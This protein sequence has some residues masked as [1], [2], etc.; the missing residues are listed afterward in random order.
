M[1]DRKQKATLT[2][3]ALLEKLRDAD[4]KKIIKQLHYY[5]LNR[6]K[7]FPQLAERYN[8][9]DLAYQFAD[10]A[11]RQVW[12]EERVWNINQY[13]DLY[14]FLKGAVDS[15]RYN[16]L[17]KKEVKI[18]TY[19]DEFT[20]ATVPYKQDDPAAKLEVKELD[21]IVK[22]IFDGDDEAYQVFDCLKNNMVP[23]DIAKEL[24]IPASQVYNATKRI[25]RKLTELRK[26]LS[27]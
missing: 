20:E 16:F 3:K 6:L 5:S 12:M 2:G 1:S 13:P 22:D 17:K 15:I 11:I 19:I 26:T 24:D 8:L 4:W 21:Q 7:Y 14:I 27:S 25:E 23:R 9:T 10:D 18:T